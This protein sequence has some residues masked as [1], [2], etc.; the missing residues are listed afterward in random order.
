MSRRPPRRRRHHLGMRLW[1]AVSFA[2]VG[3]LT[4]GI[5]YFVITGRSEVVL[6]ERST[7]LAV[8]R[9]F[10]LADRVAA[11][12][13]E[14]KDVVESAT[15]EGFTAWYFDSARGQLA[16]GPTSVPHGA[17]ALTVFVTT[18]FT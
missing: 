3:A 2:L 8:G 7:E 4:A 16:P 15:G 1:L 6:S 17:L 13:D 5:M 9:T 10:R 18:D 14:D 11:A 12:G